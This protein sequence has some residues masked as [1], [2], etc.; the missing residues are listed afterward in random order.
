MRLRWDLTI[1]LLAAAVDA[2][3][4]VAIPVLL[5]LVIDR[6]IIPKRADVVLGVAP[7]RWPRSPSSTRS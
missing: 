5:G 1:F 6:G 4:T 3:I 2:V 7:A